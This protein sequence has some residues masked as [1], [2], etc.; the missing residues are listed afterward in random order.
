MLDNIQLVFHQ[1]WRIISLLQILKRL[2]VAKQCSRQSLLGDNVELERLCR[3]VNSKKA[4]R[5]K[6]SSANVERKRATAT[7]VCLTFATIPGVFASV[8]RVPCLLSSLFYPTSP[9]LSHWL[10][11]DSLLFLFLTSLFSR[12]SQ[13]NK[14]QA[15]LQSRMRLARLDGTFDNFQMQF[16]N[17]FHHSFWGPWL[18]TTTKLRRSA[19]MFDIF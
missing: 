4:V 8:K 15:E 10:R 6:V 9:S 18:F 13:T 5:K 16:S 19:S 17:S 11:S 12:L 1:I 14:L 7:V 3:N 2:S